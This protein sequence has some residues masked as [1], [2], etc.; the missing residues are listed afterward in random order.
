MM[1]TCMDDS[2]ETDGWM[3]KKS[4]PNTSKNDHLKDSEKSQV[5]VAHAFSP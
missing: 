2:K 3:D 5:T 1:E 4:Y